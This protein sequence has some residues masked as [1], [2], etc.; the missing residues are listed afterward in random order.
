MASRY[1]ADLDALDNLKLALASLNRTKAQVST[2]AAAVASLGSEL[3]HRKPEACA[4]GTHGARLS[5]MNPGVAE[6]V[7]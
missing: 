6:E 2:V 5:R 7:A 1:N 4:I 3:S